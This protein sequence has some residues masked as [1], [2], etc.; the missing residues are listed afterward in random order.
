[1]FNPKRVQEDF[2][3]MK[4]KIHGKRLVYL[5]NAATSQK[6]QVVIDALVDYYSNHNANV[7]RGIHV[8]GDESTKMYQQARERVADFFGARGNELV[9]V[10]NTTEALNLVA[11]AWA[12]RELTQGEVIITSELEHHSDLVTWQEVAKDTGAGLT[13][14]EVNEEGE[15]DVDH[16]RALLEKLGKG[17]KL[18]ALAMVS[19][20]TGAVLDVGRVVELKKRYAREAVLVLDAAQAAPHMK[21]DFSKLEAEFV[22]FS[23]HKMYG[24]M[25]IGGLLAKEDILDSMEPFMT[26]GGM[27]RE[28][29]LTGTEYADLPD[30]YD[31]GTPN[32]G[33]A[34]ALAAAVDYL[35]G[36]GMDNVEKHGKI[37]VEYALEKLEKVEEV[38]LVGPSFAEASEGGSGKRLS[39]LGSVAFV[40]EGV[41]AHDVAQILDSEGVAVRSGHHCTM[42]LHSKFEWTATTRA[43][44]GVY[45]TREDV[46]RLIGGLNKVEQVFK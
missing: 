11:Y 3:I 28:V 10:R 45:N 12:R 8:L 15:I 16:L 32:V 46:D 25:G 36:L 29:E 18:I 13:F 6:P 42:P 34:V 4:R 26:G 9:F 41:H 19:N 1:M 43:S 7:H 37:L 27:I 33:G 21:I 44:F 38:K 30:R 35:N 14:A 2:P 31:A 40:Y 17:V 23:G 5:D 24:P 20:A 39:R 22:A